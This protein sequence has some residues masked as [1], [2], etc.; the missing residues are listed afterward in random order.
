ME[1][2]LYEFPERTVDTVGSDMSATENDRV[3][4]VDLLVVGGGKAGKTLA[5]EMAR[6][7]A[8]VAMVERGMIGG[9]CINVACIPTKTIINSGRLLRDMRRATEFGIVGA[10]HPQLEL[11]LLRRRKEDVV[12]TMVQGQLDSFLG[13]GMDF[14][15]GEARFVAPRTVSVALDAGGVRLL[16]GAD[17]VVNLGTEP[18]LPMIAGLAA[19]DVLTSNSLLRL[20][21]LPA[22]LLILGGGYVGCEFADLLNTIGVAVTIVQSGPHLLAREDDEIAE[23]I[24]Q[25][26]RDAGITVV[27]GERAEKVSRNADGTVTL[28]LASGRAL[29]ADDLLVAVGRQPVT[30]GVG[31]DAAGIEVDQRGYIV[32]DEYLRTSADRVWAAGDVAG[33]PQFTHASYDDYRVLAANLAAEHGDGSLRST[34]GRLIPYC[35]FVT[36]ELGRVGLSE[37]DARAAGFDVRMARM[38]VS[39]IP[40][41]RTV[42]HLDGIWTAVI[43]RSTNLILGVSLLGTEASEVIAAVQLAMLAGMPYPSVRDAVITHP[44]MAEGLTLLFSAAFLED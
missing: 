36:P 17:V 5:M 29:S 4:E 37:R 15:L 28:T 9:T 12:G 21:A 11:A 31:L 38:P 8:S 13:S 25:R 16:R 35:V 19:A 2:G 42:G 33:S 6:G 40:R 1:W 10:P 41:A 7:G 44:T 32:V 24:E 43:D 39:A 23:A 27:C 26:F 14:I 20:E 22:R 3:E 34:T 18:L 30:A